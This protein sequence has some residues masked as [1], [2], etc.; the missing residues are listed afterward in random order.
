MELIR[1]NVLG[2]RRRYSQF[3]TGLLVLVL[4]ISLSA[5]GNVTS[6]GQS[7]GK[8]AG[9]DETTTG[10]SLYVANAG[11]GSLLAFDPPIATQATAKI[12]FAPLVSEG[13]ILPSRR[14]PDAV[15]GA[16]GI[17]LDRTSN[18]LYVAS[19]SLNAI[20]IYENASTLTPPVAPKRVISGNKT[21]LS[22][23][24][25]L[26]YN[27]TTEQLFIANKGTNSILVFDTDCT[28]SGTLSGNIAPC[29][30]LIGEKTQ[31]D[32][33][34]ALA[35]D[36]AKDIL[37]ISN[38]GNDSILAYSSATSL[39]GT[40]EACITTF[41]PCNIIPTRVISPHTG[42]DDSSRLELP[43]GLFIDSLD[44]R[45]FVNNTGLN[46]P[47]IFIY[48][49]ASTRNGGAVPERVISGLNTQLTV[50]S[51]IDVDADAGRIVVVNNNSPNN[52]NQSSGN[53]IDSPSLVAFDNIDARCL[54]VSGSPQTCDIA[55]DQ[56]TGGDATL[57]SPIG[58]AID[59]GRNITYVAN[60][61][62]NNILV[63]SVDGDIAPVKI[64]AG[65]EDLT[66]LTQP[67][68]FFYDADLDRLYIDNAGVNGFSSN[69]ITVYD[70]VS[71][72]AF[73]NTSFSWG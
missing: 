72:K 69:P 71:N 61:G 9:L 24:F 56:R 8:N 2:G 66:G 65:K 1:C 40:T 64:N 55:P 10:G 59:P 15:D 68:A 57:S 27:P 20:F 38:M 22:Q 6:S 4:S 17:F 70:Q 18:T 23:P 60:T 34:R 26:T 32:L 36:I 25:G 67:S 73:S 11:D 12:K 3:T 29:S 39:G 53:N 13:N 42:A 31:L 52:V 5:C 51:G 35:I 50:P 54:L 49:N 45:L 58:I 43:F 16:T 44:D 63:F 41:T 46:R 33:P 30:L 21:K 7:A 37:Y 48:E 28:V 14:F 47:G 19:P 62:A